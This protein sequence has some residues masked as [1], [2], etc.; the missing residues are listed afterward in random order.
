MKTKSQLRFEKKQKENV[1]AKEIFSFLKSNFNILNELPNEIF[2]LEHRDIDEGDEFYSEQ[3]EEYLILFSDKSNYLVGYMIITEDDDNWAQAETY[4]TSKCCDYHTFNS[5]D[6]NKIWEKVKE[7]CIS[8]NLSH[9]L[10][11]K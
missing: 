5:I 4:E 8:N 1:S 3:G 11:T 6:S 10:I 9:L 7:V 2:Q